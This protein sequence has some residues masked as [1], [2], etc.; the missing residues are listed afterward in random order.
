MSSNDFSQSI[1][2][3]RTEKENNWGERRETSE[4]VDAGEESVKIWFVIF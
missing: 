1:S 3:N 4:L 2:K